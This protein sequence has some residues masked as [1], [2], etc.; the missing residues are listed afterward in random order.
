MINLNHQNLKTIVS[1][2][3]LGILKPTFDTLL[4]P[5]SLLGHGCWVGTFT[6]CVVT[7]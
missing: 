1:I 6:G 2:H 3:I 5:G 4:G 7:F